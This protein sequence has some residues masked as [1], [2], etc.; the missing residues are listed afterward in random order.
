[1]RPRPTAARGFDLDDAGVVVTGA[2]VFAL[3]WLPWYESADRI[4]TWRGVSLGFSGLVAALLS[5]DTGW[6]NAQRIEAAGGI[7]I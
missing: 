7:H 3:A 5:D 6:I 2:A 1:M 4:V